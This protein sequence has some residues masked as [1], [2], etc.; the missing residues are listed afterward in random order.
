MYRELSSC[1]QWTNISALQ[2]PDCKYR[3]NPQNPTL[4][5][6][7]T[8]MVGFVSPERHPS[9]DKQDRKSEYIKQRSAVK[10]N[11]ACSEV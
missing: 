11:L 7:F 3:N 5:R 4:T 8:Q 10:L 6:D 9:S 1:D 2:W